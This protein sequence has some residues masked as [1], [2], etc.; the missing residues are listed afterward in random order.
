M[1]GVSA[2]A[3]FRTQHAMN[4]AESEFL[5]SGVETKRE[6]EFCHSIRNA[7]CT[8]RKVGNGVS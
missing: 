3:E 1:R 5:R 8:R 7:Y 6:V 2:V 4:S